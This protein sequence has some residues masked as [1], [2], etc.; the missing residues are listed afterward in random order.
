MKKRFLVT[1]DQFCTKAWKNYGP[2][3]L[4]KL[5]QHSDVGGLPCMNCSIYSPQNISLV[6]VWLGHF[7]MLYFFCLNHFCRL[8]CVLEVTVL[9]HDPLTVKLRFRDRYS[10]IHLHNLL[11]QFRFVNNHKLFWTRSSKAAP[12]QDTAAPCASQLG[13]G[14]CAGIQY[15]VC[16]KHVFKKSYFGFM[17][18]Q[19]ILP[20][21]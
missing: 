8:T 6:K 14:S 18:P 9:L 13:W 7:R 20:T 17:C 12:N 16:T 19:H 4:K 1:G 3:L 11:E 21:G 2:L 15:L 5:L 10:G